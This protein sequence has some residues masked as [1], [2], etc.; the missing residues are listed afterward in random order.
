MKRPFELYILYSLLFV[1]SVNAL[2]AGF[3]MVAG[4]EVAGMSMTLE[5]LAHTPFKS[6]VV[7]GIILFLFNG[8]FPFFTLIGL[9][10]KPKWGWPNIINLY[11]DKHWA[12]AY[13]L[14]TGVIVITWILVQITMIEYSILQP[15]IAGIG[16]LI[17]VLTLLPRVMR[18]Y[19]L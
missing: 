5:Q 4:I 18:Y 7:P 9:A 15:V 2:F 17:L 6:F 11:K 14:Y 19:T 12:W 1:L 10:A 3:L 13:S 8:V 16:L